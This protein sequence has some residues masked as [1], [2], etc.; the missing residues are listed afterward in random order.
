LHDLVVRMAPRLRL[1]GVPVVVNKPHTIDGGLDTID[2]CV[3]LGIPLADPDA[4][5]VSFVEWFKDTSPGRRALTALVEHPTY[6]WLA[7]RAA[8][9]M[10]GSLLFTGFPMG[11]LN[12][13]VSEQQLTS[14]LWAP[15][16]TRALTA[17]LAE[18]AALID[19]APLET[20]R[21]ILRDVQ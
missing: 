11:R 7:R 21:L 14:V 8:L 9:D 19:G 15:G 10:L 6:E 18:L 17:R 5:H 2:L 20:L 4:H 16:F 13:P 3:E 12:D 1:D